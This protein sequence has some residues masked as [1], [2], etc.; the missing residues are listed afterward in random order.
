MVSRYSSEEDAMKINL[1]N[2]VRRNRKGADLR[3]F[4]GLRVKYD[5]DLVLKMAG[6]RTN[7]LIEEIK[8]RQEQEASEELAHS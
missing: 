7:K 4:G 6:R 5:A 3:E 2:L 8:K 1:K